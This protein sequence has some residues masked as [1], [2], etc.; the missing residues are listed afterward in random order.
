MLFFPQDDFD[1]D[2]IAESGQ[3]FRWEPL[4]DGGYRIPFRNSCLHIRDTENG[5]FE[6]DC[7]V[8]GI[9]FSSSFS[10]SCSSSP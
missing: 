5:K 2:R 1:L 3:C 10:P 8:D 6:L 4:E 9:P 7:S